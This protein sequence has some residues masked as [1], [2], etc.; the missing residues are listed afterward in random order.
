MLQAY[1]VENGALKPVAVDPDGG[2]PEAAVWLDMTAPSREEEA[3][4]E[5]ALGI[6]VPTR[7]EMQEIE[8]TSRLYSKGG[9]LFMTA[10]VLFH[11]TEE[12][13]QGVPVTFVLAHGRLVTVRY[14]EPRPFRTFVAT[15]GRQ[16]PVPEGGAGVFIALLEAV[17]D[18][19]ADVL[20]IVG[21][22]MDRLSKE[23][24]AQSTG[25]AGRHDF[26]GVLKRL[27]HHGLVTSKARES[28]VTLGRLFVYAGQD[29]ALNARPVQHRLK[30]L[31]RDA[32]SLVDHTDFLSNKV[33][34]VLDATLGLINIEQNA[35]IKIFSVVAVVFLPP[36]LIA[37]IY[38]MNF[39]HMPELDWWFGYPLAILAMIGSAILPYLFFKRR[40]WL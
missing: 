32:S 16:G 19:L 29:E 23:V 11:S 35:T 13:P 40:G 12:D 34:F 20:E 2:V 8:A 33:T 14:A 21:E 18:R 10:M 15:T 36:T 9:A 26:G 6:D 17:I 1:R 31:R 37:S 30:M 7:E 39:E 38:G 3:L 5:A 28:L 25:K 4:V 24:F 22:D 27:G